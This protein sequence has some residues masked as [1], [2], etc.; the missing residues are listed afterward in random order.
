[1][2]AGSFDVP[3][4][5]TGTRLRVLAYTRWMLNFDSAFLFKQQL[6][7]MPAIIHPG[8]KELDPVTDLQFFPE[9]GSLVENIGST[10]AFKA[11]NGYGKPVNISGYIVNSKGITVGSYQTAHDGMGKIRFTPLSGENYTAV[12]LDPAGKEHKTLLPAANQSGIVF[13]MGQQTSQGSF[14]IERSAQPD[15]KLQRINIVASIEQQVVF[16]ASANLTEKTK[17]SSSLPLYSFPSGVLRVTVFD[18][19]MQPLTERVLFVNNEEFRLQAAMVTDTLNLEKR[20]KNVFQIIVDDSIPASLSLSVTDGDENGDSSQNILSQLLLSA[21]IKGTIHRPADYFLSDE[22]SLKQQLDLVMLTNGWRKFIWDDVF[23]QKPPMP[24]Y[25]ADTNYLSL[26]GKINKLSDKKI[27]KAETVNLIL[28]AKDSSKQLIFTPLHEDGSFRED[29][30]VLYDTTKVYYQLNNTFLP[31]A[32]KVTVKNT[33]LPIDSTRRLNELVQ[34]LADTSGMMRIR[35]IAAEQKRV[36]KMMRETTL[37]EVVVT[38]KT[39]TRVEE[40]DDRYTK[41]LFQDGDARKF[42]LVDDIT[43][44]GYQSL[45]QYLQSRVAGLQI[46]TNNLL[47]PTATWRGRNVAFFLDEMLVDAATL[48]SIPMTNI[49]YVKTFA[50]PFVGAPGGGAGGAI[51]AYTLK[52]GDTKYVSSGMDYTL[53]PGYSALRQFYSPNYA[54]NPTNFNQT[55]TRRTLLWNPYIF[56]DGSA[57]KVTISFYNNDSSHSLRI[58]LEGM[59]ADGKLVHLSKLLK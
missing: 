2:A 45:F 9:G 56:T 13:S 27:K 8:P 41:G 11:V 57:N 54:A 31:G 5:F 49:A 17:I 3:E 47:N 52:G 15:E 44:N 33:F 24:K 4:K 21:E 43:A 19:M 42:N 18:K 32:S 48:A 23:K 59:S 38:A 50:P 26:E 16:R 34:F 35:A 20:G 12:W 25:A 55:D 37:K 29:K 28:L 7:I 58:V 1:M 22:D 51:V 46:N 14:T 30:L 10:L 39:K 53:L 6:T 40:L 36:E